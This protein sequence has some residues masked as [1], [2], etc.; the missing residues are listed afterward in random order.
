MTYTPMR[1]ALNELEQN[2]WSGV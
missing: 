2:E 1:N